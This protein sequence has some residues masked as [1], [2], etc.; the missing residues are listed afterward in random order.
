MPVFVSRDRAAA[1]DAI[2]K[3]LDTDPNNNGIFE[4]DIPKAVFAIGFEPFERP[5]RGFFPYTLNT[6]EIVLSSPLQVDTFNLYM[7]PGQ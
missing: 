4:S 6:T 5:Y 2:A 7:K 3:S 1:E